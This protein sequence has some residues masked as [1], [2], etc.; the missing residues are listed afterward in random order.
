MEPT[1]SITLSKSAMKQ[2]LEFIASMLGPTQLSTVVK[3][4]AYGHGIAEY[5]PVLYDLGIRHFSVFSADEA[6]A[7]RS[8]LPPETE[9]MVMGYLSS[10]QLDWAIETNTS[11]FV[12]D[13]GRLADALASAKRISRKAIVHLELETGMN[14]TGFQPDTWFKLIEEMKHNK[15]HLNLKGICSH[16]AGAESATNHGRVMQQI[17]RFEH[18]KALLSEKGTFPDLQFHLACSAASMRYPQTRMD[19]VRVGILQ[20]GFFPSEEM[21]AEYIA[22]NPANPN[23]LKRVL[24]WTAH[25][26]D[27]R[28]VAEGEYVGYGNS[29]CA[30]QAMTIAI[31]PVGYAHGFSR[32][33]SN[34]GQILIKGCVCPVVGI[35][36]MN[37]TIVD[38]SHCVEVCRGDEAV[39]VGRQGHAELTVASFSSY[40]EQVNYEL[41]TRL[42]MNI[43]RKI[44]P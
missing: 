42:P 21:Q 40:S 4:N 14:R 25:V 37:M 43:P 23:P 29:Y 41:L 16:L 10:D 36:N 18:F 8:V 24:S 1:S 34:S 12:F 9:V 30:E 19:L 28:T 6:F 22:A 26:L 32:N 7:V 2:N 11:F 17:Q 3:G 33:L 31:V 38:V 39:M 15:G 35:V 27:V 13:R 5:C 20:Y 44:I